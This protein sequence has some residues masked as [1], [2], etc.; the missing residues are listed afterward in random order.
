MLV[1]FHSFLF[2]RRPMKLILILLIASI[3]IIVVTLSAQV[4]WTK[5][6]PTTLQNKASIQPASGGT[7][8]LL[9]TA[10]SANRNI[11]GRLSVQP[12]ADKLRRQLGKRFLA[13][14]RE[15]SALQ[16]IV[17]SGAQRHSVRIVQS[18]EGDDVRL[19]IAL[20]GGQPLLAWSGRAGTIADDNPVVGGLHKLVERLSLDRPDHFVLAQ[21][22]GASYHTVAYAARPA[23]AGG[24]DSYTGPVWDVVRVSEP[25]ID[26]E[27]NKPLSLWRLYYINHA[28]GL[29][30]RVV[31][32]EDGGVVTAEISGWVTQ[33]GE[34]APTHI[35][36]TRNNQ[37]VMELHIHNIEYGSN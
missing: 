15:V 3:V 23:E 21:L 4:M 37:V 32:E 28:T 16:G 12:Q 5:S 1:R 19:A 35:T 8:P 11:Y 7:L 13:P 2:N 34:Q 27:A 36:W 22:R 33:N 30:D 14:G 25:D 31:S 29:I 20:D 6:D 9:Q 24:S 18:Q 17:T 26:R 10:R